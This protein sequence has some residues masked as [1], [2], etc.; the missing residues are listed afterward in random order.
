MPDVRDARVRKEGNSRNIQQKSVYRIHRREARQGARQGGF[1]GRPQRSDRRIHNRGS[2]PH[3][4]D[5][6]HQHT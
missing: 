1:P 5:K 6:S 4:R 3:A 2:L